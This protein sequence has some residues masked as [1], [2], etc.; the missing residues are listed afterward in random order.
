MYRLYPLDGYDYQSTYGAKCFGGCLVFFLFVDVVPLLALFIVKASLYTVCSLYR[1]A[2]SQFFNNKKTVA[3]NNEYC[4]CKA[5][6]HLPCLEN[7]IQR[8]IADKQNT[9]QRKMMS[10]FTHALQHPH[11]NRFYYLDD[12]MNLYINGNVKQMCTC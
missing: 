12:F 9:E 6:L 1:T 2:G 3:Q 10:Q 8:R 4:S 5:T 11:L 7:K